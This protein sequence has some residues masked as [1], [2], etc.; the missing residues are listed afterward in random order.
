MY[1]ILFK[2][3]WPSSKLQVS[4]AMEELKNTMYPGQMA[5]IMQCTLQQII[6][7]RVAECGGPTEP[8]YVE[9]NVGL[10]FLNTSKL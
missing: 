5:S 2:C 6:E 7:T 8:E 10:H 1:F 3:R 4:Y 9:I